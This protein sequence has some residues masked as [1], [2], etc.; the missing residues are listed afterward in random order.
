MNFVE[1]R[2]TIKELQDLASS[3]TRLSKSDLDRMTI[4]NEKCLSLKEKA[5][6]SFSQMVKEVEDGLT[7]LIDRFDQL[8]KELDT[9]TGPEGTLEDAL[10]LEPAWLQTND[11]YNSIQ[12]LTKSNTLPEKKKTSPEMPE[13]GEEPDKKQPDGIQDIIV[14]ARKEA[15]AAVEK[16]ASNPKASPAGSKPASVNPVKVQYPKQVN[17]KA[18]QPRKEQTP[19]SGV[20]SAKPLPVAKVCGDAEQRLMEE[21]NKNIEL[22]KSKKK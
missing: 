14:L 11:L 17:K 9:I 18:A 22:I 2:D 3:Y 8:K 16:S 13:Q 5:V 10:K 1:Y 19:V 20:F 21:I 12:L 7:G 4:L 15:A 6:R